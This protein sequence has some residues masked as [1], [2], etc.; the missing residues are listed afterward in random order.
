MA[1]ITGHMEAH[2]MKNFEGQIISMSADG[3]ERTVVVEVISEVACERCASG[4][5]CG[6][7]LLGGKTSNRRVAATVV[8]DLNVSNGDQVSISLEPQNLLRAAIIVY[9]YPMFAAVLAAIVAHF[10]DAN[11]AISALLALAGLSAGVLIAK[12][13]LGRAR[14]LREFTP[15]VV[16][17]LTSARD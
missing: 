7:G 13:I 2:C 8:A 16:D 15:L 17:R 10:Y 4:K 3:S 12:A 1:L 6:A 5:G 11:D 14:C 9:G